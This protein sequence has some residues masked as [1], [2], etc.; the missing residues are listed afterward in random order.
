MLGSRLVAAETMENNTNMVAYTY[1]W[2]SFVNI[3]GNEQRLFLL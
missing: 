1:K 2:H 3:T